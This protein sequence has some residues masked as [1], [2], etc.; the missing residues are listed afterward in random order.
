MTE[1]GFATILGLCLILAIAL[2][3]KGIQESE[4]NHANETADFQA[5]IDLQSAAEFGIY[6]VAA[7]VKENPLPLNDV[8]EQSRIR[9]QE[10]QERGKVI[11]GE[12]IETSSGSV[13]VDVWGE[14]LIINPYEV[15]YKPKS[16][17]ANSIKD[18]DK[19]KFYWIGYSFFSKAEFDK[20]KLDNPQTS[21]KLYLRAFAS[22]YVVEKKVTEKTVTITLPNGKTYKDKVKEIEDVGISEKKVIHFMNAVTVDYTYND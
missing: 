13:S 21:R 17:V 2:V 15:D 7:Y 16:D 4:G 18:E 14:R 19:N 20:T 1:K 22:A 11:N 3:V 6:K 5:E 12:S 8:Y 9:R 10:I